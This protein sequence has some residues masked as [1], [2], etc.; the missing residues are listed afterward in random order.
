MAQWLRPPTSPH[1]AVTSLSSFIPSPF[2][3][4][5]GSIALQPGAPVTSVRHHCGMV[6]LDC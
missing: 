3:S 1:L 5:C 6:G 4:P 2:R